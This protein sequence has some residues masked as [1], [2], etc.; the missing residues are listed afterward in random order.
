MFTIILLLYFQQGLDVTLDQASLRGE[1]HTM[2]DCEAAARKLRGPLPIPR[3]MQAAW[4]DAMCVKINNNVHV[5]AMK[6][7]ELG[8][9]LQREPPQG[10]QAEGAWARLAD[11]CGPAAPDAQP[12]EPAPAER[13]GR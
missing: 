3:N 6:P 2:A 13:P 5:N 12:V 9:L 1:F 11:M 10:C 4:Q 8:K 7:V